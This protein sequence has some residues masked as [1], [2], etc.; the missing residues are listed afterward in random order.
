MMRDMPIMEAESGNSFVSGSK[1]AL[2]HRQQVEQLMKDAQVDHLLIETDKP[3]VKPLR[4]FL[5]SRGMFTG[6]E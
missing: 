2:S 3:L 4:H 6:K 1:K 5:Q